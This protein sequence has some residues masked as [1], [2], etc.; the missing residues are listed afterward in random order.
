[1]VFDVNYFLIRLFFLAHL[2]FV[3]LSL[4]FYLLRPLQPV[5]DDIFPIPNF[6]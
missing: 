1:M 3:F 5:H 2:L 6:L 4:I